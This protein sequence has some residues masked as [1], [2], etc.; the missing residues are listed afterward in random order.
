MHNLVKNACEA[1]APGGHVAISLL[2]SQ[3]MLVTV[4]NTG[5]VPSAMR[6]RFFDRYTSSGKRQGT[7]L[8]TYSAKLLTEAM[9]GAVTMA[10][11]D[12]QN[13]T[14]LTVTLPKYNT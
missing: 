8:G 4:T 1:A 6:E 13:R 7:G 11:D 12:A 2:D 5:T 9:H 3:P 10:T 14:T